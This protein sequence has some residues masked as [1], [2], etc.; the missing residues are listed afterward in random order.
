MGEAGTL[1]HK[2]NTHLAQEMEDLKKVPREG[3]TIVDSSAAPHQ[4]EPT[5]DTCELQNSCYFTSTSQISP[6]NLS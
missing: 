2:P 4:G 1:S 6:K 5:G 3:R